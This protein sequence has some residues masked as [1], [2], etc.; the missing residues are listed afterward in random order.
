MRKHL[1]KH[2]NSYA[3]V[4]DK[5]ILDLLHISPDT[6]LDINT[7]G[8]SLTITPVRDEKR[9]KRLKDSLGKLNRKFN[10]AMKKLAE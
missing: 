5:P 4:I 1:T 9:R 2:G 8:D 7:D 10:P 3:L 6:P